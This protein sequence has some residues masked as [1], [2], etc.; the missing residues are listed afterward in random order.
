MIT[1][2]LDRGEHNWTWTLLH[3]GEWLGS[4]LAADGDAALVAARSRLDARLDAGLE[5]ELCDSFWR[6]SAIVRR[7]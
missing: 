7:G 1:L 2:V 5:A 6:R 4:G 3:D